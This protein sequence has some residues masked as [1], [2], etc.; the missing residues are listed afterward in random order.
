[1]FNKSLFLQINSRNRRVCF[2]SR[3]DS[4]SI[5]VPS[6]LKYQMILDTM[7]DL[8]IISSSLCILS[9]LMCNLYLYW[10]RVPPLPS[11]L[12]VAEPGIRIHKKEIHE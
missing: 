3:L 1:M 8:Y 4:I 12:Q 9:C 7:N 11:L 5:P 10:F 2:F 6:L